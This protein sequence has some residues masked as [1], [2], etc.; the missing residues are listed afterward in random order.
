MSR[1]ITPIAACI[2]ILLA[3]A[4]LALF[5][6]GGAFQLYRPATASVGGPASSPG[7]RMQSLG[8]QTAIGRTASPNF[9]LEHGFYTPAGLP[10][11]A[12]EE[13]TEAPPASIRLDS[14]HPNPFNPSTTIAF[15]LPATVPTTLKI[16]NM[17]G[18][19]VRTLLDEPRPAGRHRIPWN[20][21]DDRGATVSSGL[22]LLTMTAGD[23]R[24]R[25]KLTLLK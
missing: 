8:G 20:G 15:E 3:S 17:K 16:Y 7:Y 1:H 10:F 13:K 22:Y 5:S 21:L 9:G 6:T 11:A 23:Y 25:R 12:V 14:V 19:L 4:A 2:L 18:Q 24:A